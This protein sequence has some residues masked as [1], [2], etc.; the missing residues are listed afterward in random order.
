VDRGG[1]VKREK[2]GFRAAKVLSKNKGQRYYDWRITKEGKFEYFE[3]PVNLEREKKIEGKYLIQ[4]EEKS[5]SAVEAV[6]RYKEL[7]DV[8]RG[9]ASLKDVLEMRPIY[10][11]TEPRVKAHIFV[12]YLAFLFERVLEK[13][14]K[15]KGMPMSVSE[16]LEALDAI[17]VVEFQMGDEKKTG[18]TPGDARTREV[19]QVLGVEKPA[20]PP[21]FARQKRNVGAQKNI[22]TDIL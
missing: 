5:L 8:E 11:R 1:L 15:G 20:L 17:H 18:V 16:A 2:I 3:H 12:A 7:W 4:T 19:L 22:S 6:Q 13:E 9:F 10:H 14:I 21:P